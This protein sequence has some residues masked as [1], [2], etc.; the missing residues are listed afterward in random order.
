MGVPVNPYNN[1]QGY[2]YNY[3]N[4]YNNNYVPP[5]QIP[6]QYRND[7]YYNPEELRVAVA[8]DR[9]NG[10]KVCFV[11]LIVFVVIGIAT[12]IGISKN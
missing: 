8:P 7:G 10:A 6:P 1:N 4:G 5:G 11:I 3:N 2:N 12:T 9:R